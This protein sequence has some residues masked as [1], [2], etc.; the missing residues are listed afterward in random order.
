MGKDEL[1]EALADIEHQRWSE[2]QRYLHSRGY[3]LEHDTYLEARH[4]DGE[5]VYAEMLS[6]TLLLNRSHVLGWERQIATPYVDLSEAE[7]QSDRDQ[8]MRY[9]PVLVEF[10]ADWLEHIPIVD[11]EGEPI[12]LAQ[13]WREE[14]A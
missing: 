7:K 11:E 4:E 2:W 9:W 5:P 10:V 8:V 13:R 12:D 3:R 1:I 6:G 14:M